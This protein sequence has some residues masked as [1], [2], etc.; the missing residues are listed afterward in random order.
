M[1][2]RVY[3][4][5]NTGSGGK[6]AALS[7]LRDMLDDAG[8]VYDLQEV[9]T[10][11]EL[12]HAIASLKPTRYDAVLAYG[13]DGSV[14][15]VAH[16]LAGAKVPLCVLPGGTNNGL[17]ASFKQSFAPQK[18]LQAIIDGRYE[19]VDIDVAYIDD[20]HNKPF[21]YDLHYGVMARV[22]ARTDR[23]LKQRVG[24]IAYAIEAIK[25]A[26]LAD[27]HDFVLR[28][29]GRER[30]AQAVM[31]YISNAGTP[32]LFGA[33]IFNARPVTDGQLDVAIVKTIRFWP[34]FLWYLGKRWFGRGGSF[35]VELHRAEEVEVLQAP[36][37]VFYDDVTTPLKPPFT[38]RVRERQLRVL[39]PRRTT[40][41]EGARAFW[42]RVKTS[43]WRIIDQ[44]RRILFGMSAQRFSQ[45]DE[46]LFI[47]GQPGWFLGARSLSRWG[48]TAVVDMRTSKPR[49][50]PKDVAILHLPTPN[51]HPISLADLERGTEFIA[52]QIK[53]GGN[54][55]V[56]CQAGEGRAASMVIAYLVSQGMF[57]RD[58][59]QYVKEHRVF[60]R[61]NKKQLNRLRQFA[62]KVTGVQK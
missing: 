57:L 15:Q 44:T 22:V 60:I 56:H 28:L 41:T 45:V 61:P 34:L 10:Q 12:A 6:G 23:R 59:L 35:A 17:A 47:G 16:R 55:Y 52:R 48:I 18:T 49:N 8:I 4:M 7:E 1:L 33:P 13:G 21:V 36:P 29:D 32:H 20:K 39:V 38:I 30:K 9:Y 14:L 11:K 25:Q 31:C 51:Y 46:H 58:A 43:V 2:K 5:A 54:V 26:Q 37:E 62:R 53:K 24:S 50:L 42:L 27:A 3:L 19:P 40:V